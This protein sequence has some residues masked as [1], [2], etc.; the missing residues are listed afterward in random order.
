MEMSSC[1]DLTGPNSVARTTLDG[2]SEGAKRA[3]D[4]TINKTL[5]KKINKEVTNTILDVAHR[6]LL[7]RMNLEHLTKS[8]ARPEKMVHLLK[9]DMLSLMGTIH[10]IKVGDW[11]EVQYEYAPGTCSDGGIGTVSAVN[12]DETGNVFCSVG[13]VLD[14]RIETGIEARRVTVTMM[15]YKDI[16]TAYRARREPIVDKEVLLPSRAVVVPTRSPLE[17]LDYGLKSRTHEKP[18]WLKEKLLH[19]GLMAATREAMWQRILSDYKCQ[20]SAVEGMRLA[21]GASFIDP[22]EHKGNQGG[23]GKF[24]S[25]KKDS[26]VG[27]PKICG[28]Y[29]IYYMPMM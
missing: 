8:V 20:L 25:V 13:Y 16:T 7:E 19:Y 11:V 2:L 5:K 28:Q 4:V 6:E 29:H 27:I 15:P 17:W 18:G 12:T 3:V 24:V 10:A 1:I 14:K 26:Q 21:L 23:G 9:P 22:R